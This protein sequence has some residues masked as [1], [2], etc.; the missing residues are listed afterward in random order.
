MEVALVV[1]HS[2]RIGAAPQN[3]VGISTSGALDESVG[4]ASAVA[5][6][7]S[8]GRIARPSPWAAFSLR[9]A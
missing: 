1:P 3:S 4:V 2:S 8:A 6:A 5:P 7:L 9:S